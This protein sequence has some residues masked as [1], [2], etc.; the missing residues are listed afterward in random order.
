MAQDIGS[1]GNSNTLVLLM[2]IIAEVVGNC[3]GVTEYHFRIVFLIVCLTSQAI[4]CCYYEK[5]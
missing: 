3:Y 1:I 2:F 4:Q 5:Y